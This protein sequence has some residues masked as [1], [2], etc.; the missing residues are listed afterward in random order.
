MSA[1]GR[2][3]QGTAGA[4]RCS[5]SS[6]AKRAF[7]SA[8]RARCFSSST[9]S[10]QTRRHACPR[11]S[12]QV[13]E[14]PIAG[15]I[16]LALSFC[17]SATRRPLPSGSRRA[18]PTTSGAP[19]TQTIDRHIDGRAEGDDKDVVGE[20]HRRRHLLLEMQ[21]ETGEAVGGG[22]TGFALDRSVCASA[23]ATA[24]SRTRHDTTIVQQTRQNPL[25][26]ALKDAPSGL[27]CGWR[28][29]AEPALPP[30]RR[31][32]VKRTSLSCR[33]RPFW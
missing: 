9:T 29:A 26:D 27:R 16:V 6:R 3:A 15:R 18:A 22:D 19:A 8:S 13:D 12:Q 24:S 25:N 33:E 10:W 4:R 32:A 31:H 7:F 23:A 1:V 20:P 17:L 5:S 2:R 14:Q 28:R 30:C 11:L 21:Q